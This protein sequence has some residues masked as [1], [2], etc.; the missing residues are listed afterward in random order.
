MKTNQLMTSLAEIRSYN[1]CAFGW[2]R[3]LDAKRNLEPTTEFPLIDC[4][5]SNSFDDVCW[6]LGKRERE[7][8][9]IV[10]AAKMCADSV[11]QF[12]TA[13]IAATY[14]A[15]AATYAANANATTDAAAYA[16]N[17]AAYAATAAANAAAYAT[18]YATNA[19]DEQAQLNM[20]FLRQAILDYE[21]STTEG[22]A[23]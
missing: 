7:I 8:S 15:T 1:P 19:Y 6:L 16:A 21:Q 2:K 9:I 5:D 22:S 10:K 14:A 3:I 18:A 20:Q 11:Q 12:D 17:A 13:A 23:K 4:C